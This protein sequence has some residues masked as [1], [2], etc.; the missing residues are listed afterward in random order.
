MSRI[1]ENAN[2]TSWKSNAVAKI[3]LWIF[4][5]WLKKEHTTHRTESEN[6][7]LSIVYKKVYC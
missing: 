2:V 7:I 5:D 4:H 1:Q 6:V 3:V